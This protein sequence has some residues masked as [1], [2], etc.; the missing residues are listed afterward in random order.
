[1]EK[2]TNTQ[3][4]SQL[5]KLTSIGFKIHF[6]HQA[7]AINQVDVLELTR[8]L[9]SG[10]RYEGI[11]SV[12]LPVD[13]VDGVGDERKVRASFEVKRYKELDHPNIS[14]NSNFRVHLEVDPEKI[15]NAHY[16]DVWGIAEEKINEYYAGL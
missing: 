9:S 8:T 3:F 4:A 13:I 14:E 5:K 1:M 16:R 11:M 7:W 10:N 15:F 12:H 2:Q 6:Y